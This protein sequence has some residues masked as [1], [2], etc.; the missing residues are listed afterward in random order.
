MRGRAALGVEP[1]PAV[2]AIAGD[3]ADGDARAALFGNFCEGERDALLA[4][5]AV[6]EGDGAIEIGRPHAAGKTGVG[7]EFQFALVDDPFGPGNEVRFG[8]GHLGAL[9]NVAPPAMWAG[10]AAGVLGG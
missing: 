3:R 6:D 7:K 1:V 4:Q 5:R 8:L 2:Q 9:H 10:V